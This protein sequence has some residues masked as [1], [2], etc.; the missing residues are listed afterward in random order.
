MYIRI[1]FITDS[2]VSVGTGCPGK[3]W[4]HHP[5]KHSEDVLMEHLQTLFSDGLSGV[6]LMTRLDNLEGLFQSKQVYG[7]MILLLLKNR[8]F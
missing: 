3:Q 4:I 2:V 1:N 6:E 8:H 7:S 5:W